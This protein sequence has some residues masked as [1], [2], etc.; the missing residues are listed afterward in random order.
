MTHYQ[1]IDQST[2]HPA[3]AGMHAIAVAESHLYHAR[4]IDRPAEASPRSVRRVGI[5]GATTTGMAIA[6]QL[7]EAD[8][9]VTVLDLARESLDRATASVRS[10]Y[11]EAFLAGELTAGQRDRRVALLAG[12]I[13]LHHLKDCDV[14][15]DALDTGTDM[16]VREKLLRRLNELARPDVVLVTCSPTVDINRL[17]GLARCPENV[18]GFHVAGGAGAT[19]VWEP[20]PGKATSARALATATALARSLGRSP[21]D[22]A[23][24][25]D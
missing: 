5:M 14:I 18:L 24:R 2:A 23:A 10:N 11:Q 15:M 21:E 17:A 22:L 16:D 3:Q 6:M 13:N 9:P 8:I 4:G 20:V 7:L 25:H 1:N 12:T 19:Q